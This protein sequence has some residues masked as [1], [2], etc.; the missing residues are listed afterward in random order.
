MFKQR[1]ILTVYLLWIITFGIYG[2]VWFVKTKNEMNEAG[3][4]IPTAWL[5][6]I[7][8]VNI[9]WLYKYCEGYATVAKKDNNPGVWFLVA[10]IPGINIVAP[11]LFQ[12]TFNSLSGA[13]AGSSVGMPQQQSGQDQM[14]QPQQ[15]QQPG[16][17]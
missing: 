1:N 2:I 17:I 8:I 14:Q 15:P 7:P 16:Q 4:Q 10:F 6:I 5:M 9:F 3:A 11:G 12:S 13:A